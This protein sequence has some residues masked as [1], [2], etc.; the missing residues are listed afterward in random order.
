[1]SDIA[2]EQEPKFTLA[3]IVDQY[4]MLTFNDKRTYYAN[5]L[6]IAEIVW[7]ELFLKTLF[8]V[9]QVELPVYYSKEFGYRLKKP[10]DLTRLLGVSAKYG[11]SYYP[12]IV[13]TDVP[14][15]IQFTALP[16]NCQC[17]DQAN[18]CGLVESKVETRTEIDTITLKPVILKTYFKAKADGVIKR[19]EENLVYDSATQKN[20]INVT[21]TDVATVEMKPCGCIKDTPP[22]RATI[23]T[24]CGCGYQSGISQEEQDKFLDTKFG[25]FNH[26]MEGQYINLL[27]ASSIR[28]TAEDFPK[29]LLVSY[30]SNGRNGLADSIVPDFAREA[31]F[32]GMNYYGRAYRH[33]TNRLSMRDYKFNYKSAIKD[34]QEFLN[35]IDLTAFSE[36]EKNATN[37]W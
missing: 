8:T 23:K 27:P 13:S 2:I 11:N 32:A 34:L 17:K 30:Q 10:R 29:K 22:A 7:G 31:I 15:D 36:I 21:I 1:M 12:L 20:V 3:D 37:L 26:T 35:P 18:L 19:Y 33:N 14:T 24:Y 5:H 9:K 25:Y 16:K 6:L 28:E 4:M